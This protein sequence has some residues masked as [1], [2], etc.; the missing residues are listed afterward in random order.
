MYLFPF[1]N[2]FIL[3][4]HSH[5][6]NTRGIVCKHNLVWAE[7][8]FSIFD[9]IAKYV[10]VVSVQMA[11]RCCASRRK[12]NGLGESAKPGQ[13]KGW[14]GP[15]S[16][17]IAGSGR[18]KTIRSLNRVNLEGASSHEM[19]TFESR[20]LVFA[21][22]KTSVN[23]CRMSRHLGFVHTVSNEKAKAEPILIFTSSLAWYI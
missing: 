23:V 21:L 9:T 4:S 7:L 15:L 16:H 22:V 18:A 6:N 12:G 5:I 3:A 17:P 20:I 8:K 10:L 2:S 13:L 11:E 14:L 19:R 1:A